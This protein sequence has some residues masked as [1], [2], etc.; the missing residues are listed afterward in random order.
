MI[1]R[2]LIVYLCDSVTL[3]YLFF[4]GGMGDAPNLD[5][6]IQIYGPEMIINGNTVDQLRV[7]SQRMP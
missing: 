4:G 3:S 7:Q 5:R 2:F 1:G 6:S